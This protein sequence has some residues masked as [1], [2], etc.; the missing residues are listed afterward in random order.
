MGRAVPITIKGVEYPSLS[1]AAKVLGLSTQRVSEAM[2]NGTID[3]L[4]VGPGGV[5]PVWA[6]KPVTIGDLEW[7]SRRDAALALKVSQAELSTFLAVRERIAKPEPTSRAVTIA[8]VHYPTRRAAA[9]A[10]GLSEGA[11]GT[12]I[13]LRDRLKLSDP[14]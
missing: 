6:R 5:N 1:A 2:S 12:Y 11:L 3:T 4:G 8:G 7:P 10:L 13:R 14:T 9:Q